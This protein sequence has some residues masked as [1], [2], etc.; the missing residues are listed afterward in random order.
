MSVG[1][2]SFLLQYPKLVK[3]LH[4]NQHAQE[5][6]KRDSRKCDIQSQEKVLAHL[7]F[8]GVKWLFSTGRGGR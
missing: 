6:D 8:L 2:W 1:L 5:T 3:Y 7:A 4:K